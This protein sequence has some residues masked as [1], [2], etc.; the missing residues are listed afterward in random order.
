ML[1]AADIVTF[2]REFLS[3]R[4]IDLKPQM[5]GEGLPKVLKDKHIHPVFETLT[6][7]HRQDIQKLR[8]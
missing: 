1:S 2:N 4:E 6:I 5:D 7:Y 3:F 8:P